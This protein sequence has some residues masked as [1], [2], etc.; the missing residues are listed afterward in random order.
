MD[1]LHIKEIYRQDV[2]ERSHALDLAFK[3]IY[4]HGIHHSMCVGNGEEHLKHK[5]MADLLHSPSAVHIGMQISRGLV[6]VRGC[7]VGAW[8]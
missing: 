4:G 5:H 6:K 3:L 2:D 1:V 8:V 7:G